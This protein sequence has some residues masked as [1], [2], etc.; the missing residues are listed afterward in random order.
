ME[1]R[2]GFTSFFGNVRY[3]QLLMAD[4]FGFTPPGA[5]E[6]LDHLLPKFNR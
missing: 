4:R 6:A 5:T 1:L 2:D 3:F